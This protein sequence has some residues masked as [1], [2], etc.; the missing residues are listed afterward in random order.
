[1][2]Y[3]IFLGDRSARRHEAIFWGPHGYEAVAVDVVDSTSVKHYTPVLGRLYYGALLGYFGGF[4]FWMYENNF[5][6]TLPSWMQLHALWHIMAGLGTFCAI[7]C[8]IAWRA[9][10]MGGKTT[11]DTQIGGSILPIVVVRHDN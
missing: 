5:C 2:G 8:Q 3:H 6:S 1:M 7:Q 11:I 4:V 10:E 9:E